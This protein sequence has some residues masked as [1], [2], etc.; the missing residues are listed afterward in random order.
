MPIKPSKMPNAQ[1]TFKNINLVTLFLKDAL[2]IG[3]A[4]VA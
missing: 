4:S 1:Y 2:C 3:N